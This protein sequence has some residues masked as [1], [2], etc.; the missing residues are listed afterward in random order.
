MVKTLFPDVSNTEIKKHIKQISNA[1]DSVVITPNPIWIT[2][3]GLLAYNQAI[4][5]FATYNLTGQ[6]RDQ[7]SR[8]IFHFKDS[9][10]M[11]N[12]RD[13]IFNNNLAPNAF[14][15]PNTMRNLVPNNVN[16]PVPIGR[17]Y[18]VLKVRVRKSDYA[19]DSRFFKLVDL[20][21][22]R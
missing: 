20:F 3:Y 5:V 7:D 2:N 18:V 21:Q 15:A 4:D 6:R 9:Q 14:H 16:N 1:D 8:C 13:N 19:E 11:Y 10:E 22:N 12:V 17:A